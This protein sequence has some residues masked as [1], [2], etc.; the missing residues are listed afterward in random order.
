MPIITVREPITIPGNNSKKYITIKVSS[1]TN[2]SSAASISV[3]NLNQ[4]VKMSKSRYEEII[5]FILMLFLFLLKVRNNQVN[6][7]LNSVRSINT[8]MSDKMENHH[9]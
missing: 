7:R 3:G 5:F 1:L 6:T 2:A 4:L 9:T 8:V